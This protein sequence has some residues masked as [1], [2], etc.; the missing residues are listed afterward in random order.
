MNDRQQT[1]YDAFEL[2]VQ[3]KNEDLPRDEDLNTIATSE[4]LDRRMTRIMHRQKRGYY[5]LFGTVGR[6]VASVLVALLVALTTVT[7]SV[8]ALRNKVAEFFFDVFDEYTL[9]NVFTEFGEMN[10]VPFECIHPTYIPQGYAVESKTDYDENY[11]IRYQSAD[12][13]KHLSYRQGWKDFTM[14]IDTEGSAY[15]EITVGNMTGFTFSNKGRTTLVLLDDTYHYVFYGT[16][17]L[18]ELVKMA[19]SLEA[20]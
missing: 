12:E 4:S 1:L 20:E 14:R 18:E 19:E 3:R 5:V 10:D 13:Q 8:E 9:I 7:F 6:R 2:Y 16:C 11:E 15:A 17:P